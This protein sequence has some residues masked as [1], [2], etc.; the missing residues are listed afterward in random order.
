VNELEIL[1]ASGM[2]AEEA[3]TALAELHSQ[4][5]AEG[6]ILVEYRNMMGVALV[7]HFGE[8]AGRAAVV[9][10]TYLQREQVA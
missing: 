7:E 6:Q 8:L 4:M 9:L 10:L 2:T 1:L 5:E 3:S